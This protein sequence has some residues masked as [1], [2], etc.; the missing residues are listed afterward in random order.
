MYILLKV[1]YKTDLMPEA[2]TVVWS[3]AHKGIAGAG[4]SWQFPMAKPVRSRNFILP[5]QDKRSQQ[6]AGAG[7]NARKKWALV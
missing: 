7:Y 4:F 2:W 1:N 3:C 5:M 6:I